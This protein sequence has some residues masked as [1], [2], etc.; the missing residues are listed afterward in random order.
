M[1]VEFLLVSPAFQRVV[2]PYTKNLARLGIKSSIRVIDSAQYE[3]RTQDFDYDIII[4]GWGQSHSPGNEQAAT[5]AP[6]RPA[7]RAAATMS[8]SRTRRSTS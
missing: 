6:R 7:R 4:G 5:G 3:R 8:A 1:A 2:Q